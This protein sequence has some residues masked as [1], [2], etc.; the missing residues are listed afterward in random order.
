[1]R[2]LTT[3]FAGLLLLAPGR[4][5]AYGPGMVLTATNT[6]SR[7]IPYQESF[8]RFSDDFPFFSRAG[9]GSGNLFGWYSGDRGTEARVGGMPPG[10]I[11]GDNQP[12]PHATH[13]RALHVSG[14]ITNRFASTDFHPEVYVDLMLMPLRAYD[15][16]I[17]LHSEAR[18]SRMATY[19]NSN[20]H[21][22]VWHM[23][24]DAG[25]RNVWTTLEHWP[26][27]PDEWIRLTVQFAFDPDR[28]R[29]LD[30]FRLR[31][32]EATELFSERARSL[33]F[34]QGQPGGTH[35]L[36]GRSAGAAN[37][38]VSN[39]AIVGDSTWIDDLTVRVDDP[40]PVAN[41]RF[42]RVA[43]PNPDFG[44][45]VGATNV[46]YGG[47]RTFAFRPASGYGVYSVDNNGSLSIQEPMRVTFTN[48]ID[49]SHALEVL[50]GPALK[51]VR[52]SDPA[53]IA[54]NHGG[55]RTA[56]EY[57]AI[58]DARRMPEIIS[59]AQDNM[60][61]DQAATLR[62]AAVH[63]RTSGPQSYGTTVSSIAYPLFASVTNTIWAAPGYY[64][65][66]AST[67]GIPI[68][69]NG[70]D[71][72]FGPTGVNSRAYTLVWDDFDLWAPGT[73]SVLEAVFDIESR[74][75]TLVSPYGRA[76]ATVTA[77]WHH[78][79]QVTGA[80]YP[81]AFRAFDWDT[82]LE[83]KILDSPF[84][85]PGGGKQYVTVGWS[86]SGSDQL[87]AGPGYRDLPGRDHNLI[88]HT[89][90]GTQ[91]PSFDLTNDT[92]VTFFWATNY[93]L[94]AF[95]DGVGTLTMRDAAGRFGV[96]NGWVAAGKSITILAEPSESFERWS[97]ETNGVVFLEQTRDSGNFNT[98][99]IPITQSRRIIAH[100]LEKTLT[101]SSA[102]GGTEPGSIRA[103]VDTEV[104]QRITNSPVVL[105]ENVKYVV[106]GWS[107]TGVFRAG[108]TGS[109]AGPVGLTS[110]STI[111]W[112]WSTQSWFSI[113][114]AGNGT[115]VSTTEHADGAVV[116]QG[117]WLAGDTMVTVAAE[118]EKA[119][120]FDRWVGD[121]DDQDDATNAVLTLAMSRKRMLTA[122]F[123]PEP[124]SLSVTS[125]WGG[126][127]LDGLPIETPAKA[128]LPFGAQLPLGIEVVNSPLSDPGNARTQYVA[129]GWSASGSLTP[130]VDDVLPPA[131]FWETRHVDTGP[132]VI[133][134]DSSIDWNWRTNVWLDVR[135][136]GWEG[137]VS[138]K[139]H[140][141][142]MVE[143]VATYENWIALDSMVELTASPLEPFGF[144]TWLGDT[145]GIADPG[146][147][148]IAVPMNQ[149][150][151]LVAAFDHHRLEIVAPYGR[152]FLNE[153][154]I[155][156]GPGRNQPATYATHFIHGQDFR[157]EIW[158][159]SVTFG[160][161][162]F[163]V[164][165]WTG[166]GNVPSSAL[167]YNPDTAFEWQLDTVENRRLT[168]DSTVAWL[169]ATNFIFHILPPQGEGHVEVANLKQGGTR[170]G[171]FAADT[172]GELGWVA[173][174]TVV[175]LTPIP[176][177]DSV[178]DHWSGD[179]PE[180]LELN[181]TLELTIDRPRKIQPRFKI[182]L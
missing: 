29:G 66:S 99:V 63:S 123:A 154:E 126:V 35:F 65:V 117:V 24:E 144:R 64:I 177:P 81:G 19:V 141:A 74:N 52:K 107:G 93:L 104:T 55:I 73:A 124:Q 114:S 18:D 110:D 165:G 47:N 15:P 28:A 148:T 89:N 135:H 71:V 34:G 48:V 174:G 87:G 173:Q 14:W 75:L 23:P 79:R 80:T 102:H 175:K 182:K 91:T 119:Y 108:G 46:P 101:V 10:Y 69:E 149:A 140:A 77:C 134:E 85:A 145:K 67:N 12:I 54:A 122:Y 112:L 49:D 70:Q 30:S 9:G 53:S 84:V 41:D 97:G 105:N 51:S 25:G 146:L 158:T 103:P 40:L 162:Q 172:Q 56:P 45:V 31:L 8:E 106:T 96:S 111:E 1:M 27:D 72:A 143:N 68:L 4:L 156:E 152:M 131:P 26:I 116:D 50:F 132:L 11:Q 92:S 32:N 130:P 155:F 176:G 22:V 133:R 180:G 128:F 59:F 95:R 58:V 21:L 43:N 137:T 76:A 37:P 109:R 153:K 121:L 78:N 138:V 113:K 38:W 82:G 171:E 166:S 5:P 164:Q 127:V 100:F 6:F 115:V 20:G 151:S 90:I 168:E 3:F 17:T 118:P 169:W 94:S 86:A 129:V 159:P 160:T 136:S 57:Q 36:L 125:L 98:A 83:A 157:I 60:R 16:Q 33:P 139:T 147:A 62:N 163:V 170:Q 39:L 178:F 179:V 44:T 161:T 61:A 88:A 120:V 167:P 42:I 142:N 2:R 181:T 150:R 13:T 7:Q